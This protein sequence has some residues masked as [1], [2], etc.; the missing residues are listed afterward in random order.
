MPRRRPS[1]HTDTPKPKGKDHDRLKQIRD[2]FKLWYDA[3]KPQRDREEEPLRMYALDQW[4]EEVTK[5]RGAQPANGAIPGTPARPCLVL[6]MLRE[7]VHQIVN[8]ERESDLSVQIIPADDFGSLEQPIDPSEIELREGLVRRGQRQS[9]ASSARSW[10][11]LRAAICGRG[12]YALNTR[13]LDGRTFDQEVYYR[14]ILHQGCVLL[15]PAHEEPDG[16]DS[17][18]GFIFSKMAYEDYKAEHPRAVAGPNQYIDCSDTA[19]AGLMNDYPDWFMQDGEK[20]YVRVAEHWYTEYASRVLCEMPAGWSMVGPDGALIR[21]SVW[22]DELPE[23]APEPTQER[24]VVTKSVKW[25][26]LDGCQILDETDWPSPFVP[27]VKVLGNEIPPHKDE[28]T[29]DGIVNK[30]AIES[31][32]GRNY[33][34]SRIAEEFGLAT[35]SPLVVIEG[36]IEGYEAWWNQ[37]STRVFPYLPVKPTD[38][39]GRPAQPPYRPDKNVNVGQMAQG[40]Q[41]FMESIQSSTNVS[42]PQMGKPSRFSET[43]RGTRELINQG[44]RGTSNYMDNLERSLSYDGRIHNSLLSTIYGRPGRMVRVV[45]GESEEES[46]VVG[47]PFVMQDNGQGQQRPVPAPP[48]ST[49]QQE[50]VRQYVLT[51]KGDSANVAV[52]IAKGFDTRRQEEGAVLSEM[53]TQQPQM[54][55]IIGD[56]FFGSQDWPGAKEAKERWRAVLDPRVLQMLEQQKGGQSPIPPQ[57]LQQ[58][59]QMQMQLQQVSQAAQ[60]MQQEL[61]TQSFKVQSDERIAMAKLQSEQQ[62]ASAKLE[63]ERLIAAAKM[64]NEIQTA[65]EREAAAFQREQLKGQQKIQQI[66]TEAALTPEP[67]PP[68]ESLNG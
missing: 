43:W 18:G 49:P 59:Q 40:M 58:M 56:L 52:K 16:S 65:L 22:Q 34:A 38:L 15:D 60:Q 41:I 39:E 47:Q 4:S 7:P 28:R 67:E 21:G 61:Q 53:V 32:R 29:V 48:G 31:Q 63:N 57:A 25:C 55:S 26:K 23:N 62:I 8:Q 51:K 35:P 33:M 54:M 45:K 3:D 13:Y 46:V 30:S 36:T 66:A 19:W 50:G 64:D 27:I 12:Y 2:R 10:A 44:E 1:D 20:R 14:R 17:S 6:D 9:H 42:N 5:L 11:F 24:H 37:S 68:Q